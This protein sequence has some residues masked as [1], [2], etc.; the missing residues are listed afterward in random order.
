MTGKVKNPALKSVP[1]INSNRL[2]NDVGRRC[3]K[4]SG[5]AHVF[6]C[7]SF[8]LRHH[9]ILNSIPCVGD[10]FA[11]QGVF[12]RKSVRTNQHICTDNPRT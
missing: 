12:G 5:M 9:G 11:R 7:L 3:Q 4:D 10:A 2:T 8:A 6:N 1:A